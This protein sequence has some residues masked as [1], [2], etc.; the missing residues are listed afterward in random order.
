MEGFS[1]STE[2]GILSSLLKNIFANFLFLGY[3][4]KS[5]VYAKM[6]DFFILKKFAN[7]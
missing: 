5:G 1:E 4:W 7:V 2:G 3:G 6:P